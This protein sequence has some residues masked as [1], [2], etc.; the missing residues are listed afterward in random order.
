MIH[1]RIVSPPDRTRRVAELLCNDDAVANV[2]VL[3]EASLLPEGDVLLADVAREDAS[4]LVSDLRELDLHKDGSIV[5]QTIETALSPRA[6]K[7][8]DAA[9]G[10]EAD[11]VVWEEVETRTSESAALS[12]S[13]L[14]FMALAAMLTAV[15][16]LLDSSILVVGGMVVGPEFGPLAGLCVALVNGRAQLARRSLIALVVG[17]PVATLAAFL[18]TAA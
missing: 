1:L 8:I 15:G 2:I 10:D 16:I 9:R 18:L 13:F 5:L 14:A 12:G 7:A 3:P 6:T 4:V 11:A 17:F